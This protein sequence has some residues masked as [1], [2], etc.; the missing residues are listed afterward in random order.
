MLVLSD[1]QLLKTLPSEEATAL[2]VQFV[3]EMLGTRASPIMAPVI[4]PPAAKP[5]NALFVAA[6]VASDKLKS[7]LSCFSLSAPPDRPRRLGICRW[8]EG[9]GV[10][11]G[12]ELFR[13]LMQCIAK[14]V[15]AKRENSSNKKRQDD[16]GKDHHPFQ[17]SRINYVHD[18]FHHFILIKRHNL[19]IHVGLAW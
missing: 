15:V 18:V 11:L 7:S 4:D 16:K 12:S 19:E 13:G 9:F 10:W 8:P 14:P 6:A 1:E 2:S 17:I 3:D 5:I